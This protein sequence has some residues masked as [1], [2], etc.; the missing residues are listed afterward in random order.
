MR[1]VGTRGVCLC[2]LVSPG[3]EIE[4][5]LQ[6]SDDE[7]PWSDADDRLVTKGVERE[8]ADGAAELEHVGGR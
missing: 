2:F 4:R 3:R 5:Q 7:M 1:S 8:V 6:G